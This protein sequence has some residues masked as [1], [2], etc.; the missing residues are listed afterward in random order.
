MCG[1]AG[2]L[3]REGLAEASTVNGMCAQIRHRG[4]DDGG[5]YTDG[6]CG[7]GMRRLSIIDL[8]TGHQPISNED[9]SVWVVFNGEI[10]NFRDLRDSLASQGHSFRT[11]SDTETLVHLYEQ[12]GEEGLARLRGM[13]AY[14]IWDSRRR[15]ILLARDCF[16]KKPLYYAETPHGLYFASELKCLR[17]PGVPLEL[18]EEALRLYF[19]FGYIPD[20]RSPYRAIRKIM[21]GCWLRY[22]AAGRLTKGRYWKLPHFAG[23]DAGALDREQV[24]T[25]V[26]DTFDEAVRIRMEADVPL[27][28]FLSGGIDSSLVVASMA[29]QSSAPVRTFS[30]GFEEEDFNELPY[31][32]MVAEQYRTEHHDIM[33]RPDSVALV[34]KLVRH[35]DEPF[36]DSS[37]IPTYIVSDFAVKH[38]KVALSGDGGDELFGGYES[39]FEIEK[40]RVLD[41]IPQ[42][43]RK[44][45]SAIAEK[46]PYSAYGK[47]YLRML[48]RPSPLARYFDNHAYMGRF[49]RRRMLQPAWMLEGDVD[50]LLDTLPDSLSRSEDDVMTQA[51]YFEATAQLSGDMLVKVDRAS[52]AASLE[53]RCPMLD[54]R[55]A[56]LAVSIPYGWK[57]LNG[58]GKRIL[59][60]AMGDRLP[61]ALLNRPKKGF[62]VPLARWFRTS[63]RDFICDHLE[64]RRFRERGIVRPEFVTYLLKEHLAGRR[65]N[66]SQLYALLMLELWYR[67][68]EERTREA[69]PG[70]PAVRA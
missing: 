19:L 60:D 12:E 49:L 32:R 1:I 57:L 43:A 40:Y 37:A 33:V 62:S 58:S 28:A 64:S 18:D 27:G 11:N 25:Q 36:A 48:G 31:A 41:A 70:Q 22:S 68:E 8:S 7:I 35:F 29:R 65:N 13:F 67:E 55:L 9:G 16:G 26:R 53:V 6:P 24:R 63:L 45:L 61:A 4:P 34:S 50:F 17:L 3:L 20:P 38:V 47:N 14:C 42:P 2:Y 54:R 51:M 66:R 69:G 23:K 46:L 39:F 10:Y 30:I 15:E 44:A 52:M 56:E 5:T 21:P 59:L